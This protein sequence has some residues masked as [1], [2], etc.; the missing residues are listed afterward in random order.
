MQYILDRVYNIFPTV[1]SVGKNL[2]A[3]LK[4]LQRKNE[5]L[6]AQLRHVEVTKDL[7]LQQLKQRDVLNT[8][9]IKGLTDKY[10]EMM[11]EIEK[12]KKERAN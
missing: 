2:E 12:L 8:E 7:E 5:V 11:Q 9:G 4:A 6:R 3:Q 1:E 10:M